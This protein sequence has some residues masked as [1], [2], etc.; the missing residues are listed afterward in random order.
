MCVIVCVKETDRT[1]NG[2]GKEERGAYVCVRYKARNRTEQ[3]LK[4]CVTSRQTE[5]NEHTHT[6]MHAKWVDSEQGGSS[7]LDSGQVDRHVLPHAA[8]VRKHWQH[9]PH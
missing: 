3:T 6:E 9:I 2:G 7:D 8:H 5:Q 4:R 1:V